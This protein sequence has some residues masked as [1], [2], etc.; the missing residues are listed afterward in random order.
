MHA[1]HEYVSAG[2][3]DEITT[4][5]RVVQ[6]PPLPE[7]PEIIRGKSFAIVQAAYLGNEADGADLIRPLAELGPEMN[8]FGMVAAERARLPGDGP[9]RP[10][11]LLGLV[12]TW[13]ATSA[14]LEST[15][16]SDRRTRLGL[17]ARER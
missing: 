12:A 8:T 3:P 1:W 16:C 6:V 4:V 15:L 14:P 17:D 10:A 13:S 2:M 5:G 11:A 7:I 9:R